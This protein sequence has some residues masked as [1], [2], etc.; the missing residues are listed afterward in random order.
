M[1][2]YQQLQDDYKQAFRDKNALKKEVLGIVLATIKNKYI[3]SRQEL[4]DAEIVQIITKEVKQM[5]ETMVFLE[6]AWKSEDLALEVDKIAIL[7]V[8]LPVML[9]EEE[10]QDIVDTYKTTL[11]V[12]DLQKERG[13]LMGAIMKD[14]TGKIDTGLLQ[15]II[16]WLTQ[17]W[18]K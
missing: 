17:W 4:S 15:K 9:S 16:S 1:S 11:G 3:E 7:Q 13:K 8:Y 5:R 6:K 10:T 2:L 12:T 18:E 14:Y